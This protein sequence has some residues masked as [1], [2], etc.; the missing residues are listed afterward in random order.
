MRHFPLIGNKIPGISLTL[1]SWFP[2]VTGYCNY[3]KTPHFHCILISRFSYIENLLHFNFAYF[4]GVDILLQITLWWSANS[5]NSRV[6]KTKMGS[7]FLLYYLSGWSRKSEPQTPVSPGKIEEACC[8]WFCLFDS[9]YYVKTLC[10][11]QNQRFSDC[12]QMRTEPRPQ[13]TCTGNVN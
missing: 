10:H 7:L 12:H 5:T 6:F 3:C 11:P 4:P 13:V 1:L 9:L 8:I 2:T